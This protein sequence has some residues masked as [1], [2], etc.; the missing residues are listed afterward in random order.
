MI[1]F[2]AKL[3]H[4]PYRPV[5]GLEALL[6]TLDAYGIEQAVVSSLEAVHYL[7]PQDGND[8]LAKLIAPY[9]DRLVPFAVIKPNFAGCEADLD[10]CLGEYGMRG[11]VLYPNYHRFRL[12]DERLGALIARAASAGAPVCVQA[13]LEDP[14][15][16]YDRG[17]IVAE[18]PAPGIG[19]LARAY[20]EA[21]VVALGLKWGQPEQLGAPLPPNCWFDISNYEALEELEQGV[22]RFGAD[23]MIFG[24]NFPFFAPLANVDKL[25]CAG[26]SE[27]DRAA[28]AE[29]N[30]RRLLSGDV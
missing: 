13:G 23:R 16:Q 1:D 25:R 4:W 26:I 17:E 20:P 10:R 8:A 24:T 21:R 5:R 3:G 18:V 12:D 15:R 2:N 22:A 29:G 30:A 27:A 6:Q 14:R 28:I 11:L 19:A 9:R 7:N